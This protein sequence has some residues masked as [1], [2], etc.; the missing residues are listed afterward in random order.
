[1]VGDS[2]WNH[3]ERLT[4]WVVDDLIKVG[5]ISSRSSVIDVV[6]E[7]LPHS[8]PIY[9]KDYPAEL[10][11][12]R[13]ELSRFEN[14]KLAGRTGLF[15]YNNMDHSMENAMQLTRRPF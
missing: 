13:T 2:R 15:W 1:M 6:I 14:L 7:R 10:D 11:K 12:A 8:Y 3:G 9:H 5:M 4:D